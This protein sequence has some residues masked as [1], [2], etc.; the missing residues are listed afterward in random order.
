MDQI[1]EFYSK[2]PFPGNYSINHLMR[3]TNPPKNRYLKTISKY[4]SSG[5]RVLDIGC[6]TGLITNLFAL[7]S[8][9]YF[10]GL[11]FSDGI[12]YA[13]EFAYINNIQ[14]VSFTKQD[15][16]EYDTECKEKFD[17]IIA[18]SFVTHVP[19]YKKAFEKIQKHLAPGGTIILGVY[20]NYGKIL[21]KI[22]KIKYFSQRLYQDQEQNPFEIS[23]KNSEILKEFNRYNL[24]E[25]MPSIKNFAVEL[26]ALCNSKNGGLTMYIFKD[27]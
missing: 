20:N 7:Q 13:K 6:G 8:D 22:V 11:D 24:K 15:F 2:N 5:Q 25:I 17:I 18:Q 23:F 27:E 19:E 1:K 14:N 10:I 21:K 9:C 26:S 3:Y 4:L 16:F 12:D